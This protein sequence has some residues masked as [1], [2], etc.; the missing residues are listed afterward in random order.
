MGGVGIIDALPFR[1]EFPPS[2]FLS[3]RIVPIRPLVQED[4][5][6]FCGSKS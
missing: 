3:L 5:Q 2:F 6:Q 1:G 4:Q